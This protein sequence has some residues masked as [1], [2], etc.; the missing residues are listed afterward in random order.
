MRRGKENKNCLLFFDVEPKTLNPKQG[1]CVIGVEINEDMEMEDEFE[2]SIMSDQAS[3]FRVK[4]F[5]IQPQGLGFSYVGATLNPKAERVCRCKIRW[6]HPQ[7][8]GFSY[9]RKNVSM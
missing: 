1:V 8:L 2:D 7:G 4:L 9:V 5:R 3:G 6:N